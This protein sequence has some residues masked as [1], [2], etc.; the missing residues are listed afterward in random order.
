MTF[1]V[2]LFNYVLRTPLPDKMSFY[3]FKTAV[4]NSLNNLQPTFFGAF[5]KLR[6][7]TISFFMSVRLFAWNK[8]AP[9]GRIVMKFDI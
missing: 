6:Q 5:A 8:S 9:T 2:E 7:M 3:I 4:G 1:V